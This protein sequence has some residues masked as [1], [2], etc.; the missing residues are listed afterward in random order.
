MNVEPSSSDCGRKKEVGDCKKRRHSASISPG[1]LVRNWSPAFKEWSTRS[2][3]D[4]FYASPVFPRLLN[5]ESIKQTVTRGV[6]DGLLGYV[7]KGADGKYITFAF[8]R[9]LEP[10]D[11]EI[12]DETF[13]ITRETALAYREAQAKPAVP[14]T[15]ITTGVHPPVT[16]A[17]EET[18]TPGTPAKSTS[19]SASVRALSWSGEIP[20][21]KW[22]NFYTRV[23][24]K[25]ATGSGLRVSVKV[26]IAPEGGVS[27]QKIEETRSA[28]RELG[29]NDMLDKDP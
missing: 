29:L 25:F 24:A 22:M 16:P 3:R 2:I 1:F 11:I 12:S 5:A 9:S 18:T 27:Q 17:V 20:S 7:S 4:A 10:P 6:Q 23:L 15:P 21:Q 14:A 13:I 28:L 19:P 8:E 26:E